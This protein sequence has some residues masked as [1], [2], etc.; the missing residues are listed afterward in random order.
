MLS[1]HQLEHSQLAEWSEEIDVNDLL[2]RGE[3]HHVSHQFREPVC[4]QSHSPQGILQRVGKTLAV[5]ASMYHHPRVPERL[6]E[7]GEFQRCNVLSL[8]VPEAAQAKHATRTFRPSCTFF[9]KPFLNCLVRTCARKRHA[10][11]WT[12]R[13]L[14]RPPDRH[15]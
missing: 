15:R 10:A 11:L 3:V 12:S 5:S 7:T 4:S 1:L 9:R 14:P 2:E 13:S 8:T 6:S